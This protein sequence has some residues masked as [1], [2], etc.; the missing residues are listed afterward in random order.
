MAAD[1][2]L[3]L[4]DELDQ[5]TRGLNEIVLSNES[6]DVTILG[7]VKPTF[8]KAI[9]EML[10]NAKVFDT[11]DKGLAAVDENG[12]FTVGA[13]ESN[14][15]HFSVAYRKMNGEAVKVATIPNG[16]TI[17]EI[18]DIIRAGSQK[19]LALVVRDA[20]NG[21]A[22]SLDWLGIL[23]S[24][25]MI[26]KDL[27]GIPDLQLTQGN[28]G[29][30]LLW[31][32][33][34]DG[35]IGL[36]LGKSGTL[37]IHSI[38]IG[39]RVMRLESNRNINNAFIIAQDGDLS[40]ILAYFNS[41]N[42]FN[43]HSLKA[44]GDVYVD[45]ELLVKGRSIGDTVTQLVSNHEQ[46]NRYQPKPLYGIVH[47][48]SDG[49]SQSIGS[50][51]GAAPK[52]FRYVINGENSSY[53]LMPKGGLRNGSPVSNE[54]ARASDYFDP[55]PLHEV[56]QGAWCETAASTYANKIQADFPDEVDRKEFQIYAT[57]SGFGSHTVAQL[58]PGTEEHERLLM[59][60]DGVYNYAQSLGLPVSI[61]MMYWW[62]AH[63][64]QRTGTA[65]GT[66]I[67]RMQ[68]IFDSIKQ[69]IADRQGKAV[70]DISLP[71]FM[72]QPDNFLY[73]SYADINKAAAISKA[74][75][76]YVETHNDVVLI[77]F[78][79][80]TNA[81]GTVH[82][83]PITY[84]RMGVYHAIA[85]RERI[86]KG[87][88]EF[89]GV[90][91]KRWWREG[92][93]LTVEFHTT[94]GGLQFWQGPETAPISEI[95]N[96]GFNAYDADMN[97]LEIASVNITG[98]N[99]VSI[100]LKNEWKAGDFIGYA[101]SDNGDGGKARVGGNRGWLF[102]QNGERDKVTLADIEYEFHWPSCQFLKEIK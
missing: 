83:D 5:L 97:D 58:S 30:A 65:A 10:A 52:E 41:Q 16:K 68:V 71:V 48:L 73:F 38:D 56:V 2:S 20:F 19:D 74:Y 77:P 18:A 95:A 78:Y 60:I 101:W 94:Y 49:Q 79:W 82:C 32:K 43:I 11:V 91:P 42:E 24:V 3:Q 50:V 86:I 62:Q 81:D 17:D 36:A 51:G 92:K 15:E 102:D 46:F 44:H 87:D 39:G 57:N 7:T 90:R 63:D 93:V 85:T 100:T 59:A 33:G 88:T 40:K 84:A 9:N 23:R 8:A 98:S 37:Y 4:I 54:D 28:D 70:A 99:K 35:G 12:F 45:G 26:A 76:E 80:A 22:M 31:I 29:R 1:N 6:K 96:Y 89:T 64:D 67:A 27:I 21:V 69:K 72:V 53:A 55:V 75:L 13:S 66:Y 61:P 14:S 34:E 47:Y 25:G